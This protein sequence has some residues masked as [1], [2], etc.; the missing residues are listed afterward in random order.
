MFCLQ[1]EEIVVAVV[2]PTGCCR[3]SSNWLLHCMKCHIATAR[4]SKFA[5]VSFIREGVHR[6]RLSAS[7]TVT[8]DQSS[9]NIWEVG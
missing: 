1:S 2:P 5:V 9:D 7:H 3:C 4:H 6:V 8:F